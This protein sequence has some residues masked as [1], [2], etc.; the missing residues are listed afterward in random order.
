MLMCVANMKGN[1]FAH[2]FVSSVRLRA[3]QSVVAPEL[4]NNLFTYAK[5]KC[6]LNLSR[7]RKEHNL[8]IIISMQSRVA[9]AFSLQTCVLLANLYNGTIGA[10]TRRDAASE[11]LDQVSLR[12]VM[13]TQSLKLRFPKCLEHPFVYCVAFTST[14]NWQLHTFVC[15]IQSISNL[16]NITKSQH[17]IFILITLMF[18]V[19]VKIKL[20]FQTY[21]IA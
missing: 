14:F 4:S 10:A 8:Q 2:L 11:K 15:T 21:F 16:T 7:F 18:L 6:T 3:N 12:R 20:H 9:Q 5:S 17:E 19:K 13:P 1:S